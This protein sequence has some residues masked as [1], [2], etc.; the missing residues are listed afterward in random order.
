MTWR[1][2]EFLAE[3]GYKRATHIQRIIAER[4]GQHLCIQAVCDLLNKEPKML[5]IETMQLLCDAFYCKLSDFCDVVPQATSREVKR[6]QNS[7]ATAKRVESKR[8][9]AKG[10]RIN[11]ADFFPDAHQ[12]ADS[13]SS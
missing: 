8:A 6:K 12:Y 3:R 2:R 13:T 4:T 9:I 5:R 10:A 1:L 7:H 11:Y